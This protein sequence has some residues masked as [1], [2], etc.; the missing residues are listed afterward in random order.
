MAVLTAPHTLIKIRTQS[1]RRFALVVE[2]TQGQ[3]KP[4][5]CVLKRSDSTQVLLT[6]ARRFRGRTSFVPG[7]YLTIHDVVTGESTEAV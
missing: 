4:T 2:Y 5:A 1:S 6:E 3:T 7:R